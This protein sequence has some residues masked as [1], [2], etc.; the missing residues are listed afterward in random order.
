[1]KYCLSSRQT[2]EYLKR[3]DEIKVKYKD[4]DIIYDY[5]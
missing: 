4:R 1:M 2:N 3:A 5:S